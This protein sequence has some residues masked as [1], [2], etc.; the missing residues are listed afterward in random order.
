MIVV[1][2][3]K[4]TTASERILV[5]ILA[6]GLAIMLVVLPVHAFVST[7]GGTAIGPLLVWKSWKEILML[8]MVPLVIWL[9]CLRPDIA[10]A[11]WRGWLSKVIV[12]YVVLSVVWAVFSAASSD[13]VIA[14]LLM[15]LRFLAVLV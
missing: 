15:N 7:W 1:V 3:R 11:V 10:R 12:A 9:C 6:A 5:A 8:L 4:K 13:A 14:G 2:N